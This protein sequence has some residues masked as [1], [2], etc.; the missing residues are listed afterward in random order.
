MNSA[1]G[2]LSGLIQSGGDTGNNGT[3]ENATVSGGVLTNNETGKLGQTNLTAGTLDNSGSVANLTIGKA[4]VFTNTAEGTAAKVSSLGQ[5]TNEGTIGNLQIDGGTFENAGNITENASVNGGSLTSTGVIGGKLMTQGGTVDLS[6]SVDGGINNGANGAINL[7]GNITGGGDFINDGTV[8]TFAKTSISGFGTLKNNGTLSMRGDL[9]VAGDFIS[10]GKIEMGSDVTQFESLNVEGDLTLTKTSVT[11]LNI[12]VDGTG[13]TLSAGGDLNLGGTLN[14]AATGEGYGLKSTFDI[15]KSTAGTVAGQFVDVVVSGTKDLFGIAEN[16]ATGRVL[17]LRNR[18]ALNTKLETLELGED[19]KILTGIE[20]K[21]E[22]GA[23]LFDTLAELKSEDAPGL[24]SQITG[25]ASSAFVNAGSNAAKGFGRLMQKV[26][27][28]SGLGRNEQG[29]LAYEKA[30]AA[31]VESKFEP[32]LQKGQGAVG[33][34]ARGFGE[35]GS[36]NAGAKDTIGGLGAGLEVA[37]GEGLTVGAS[38]GYS[39][40]TFG[41]GQATKGKT[42]SF[43]VGTY[44]AAGATAPEAAGFGLTASGS[45]SKHDTSS[46]RSFQLGTLKQIANA[47]YGGSTIAG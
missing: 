29:I 26:A 44:V 41:N 6:G 8:G 31:E 47:K 35:A 2:T 14:V 18:A 42:N 19:A 46:S 28:A 3:I 15:F 16:S 27:T 36:G 11:S 10:S 23:A 33:F 12:A 17:A 43:H 22:D 9:N 24:L 5:G 45:F 32:V 34:W 1:L 30:M 13:D 21:G 25:A 40:A 7:R 20:Y 37:M 38:A 39:M 4:G